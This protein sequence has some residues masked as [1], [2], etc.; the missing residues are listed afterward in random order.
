MN[1]CHHTDDVT[2]AK[3]LYKDVTP[4]ER[5]AAIMLARARTLP[6]RSPLVQGTAAY[7][8]ATGT[9]SSEWCIDGVPWS[10]VCDKGVSISVPLHPAPHWVPAEG[11]LIGTALL[12][13]DAAV[14]DGLVYAGTG[15]CAGAEATVKRIVA[16]LP[17]TLVHGARILD[18]LCM[19]ENVFWIA[20][21]MVQY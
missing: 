4:E 3:D 14:G 11:K 2:Q 20:R 15:V 16:S 7:V 10:Q 18:E 21:L 19:L 13:D 12:A 9:T 6:A 17:S 8:Q 5:D 1:S